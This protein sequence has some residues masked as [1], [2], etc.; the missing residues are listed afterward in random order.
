MLPIVNVIEAAMALK[1]EDFS[2]KPETKVSEALR[3]LARPL[4]SEAAKDNE[5]LRDLKVESRCVRFEA[6]V[7]EALGI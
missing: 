7:S 3:P 4:T 5:P 6:I 2:A 1:I